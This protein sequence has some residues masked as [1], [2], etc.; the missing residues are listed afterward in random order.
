MKDILLGIVALVIAVIFAIGV[1]LLFG[2]I[3]YYGLQTLGV[4]LTFGQAVVLAV[5]IVVTGILFRG[6]ERKQTKGDDALSE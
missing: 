6:K 2:A 1:Y 5:L 4:E 3:Y